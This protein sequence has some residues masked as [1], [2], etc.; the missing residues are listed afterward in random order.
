MRP[1]RGMSQILF[2]SEKASL[3][4][5]PAYIYLSADLARGIAKIQREEGHHAM[6]AEAGF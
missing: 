3:K 4:L 6:T 1:L 5:L 2:E